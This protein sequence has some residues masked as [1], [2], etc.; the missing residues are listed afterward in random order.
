MSSQG[1]RCL[2]LMQQMLTDGSTKMIHHRCNLE[3]LVNDHPRLALISGDVFHPY[4]ELIMLK[5]FCPVR[6]QDVLLQQGVGAETMTAAV[7][8]TKKPP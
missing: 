2:E 4:S 1:A 7:S 8:D 5:L 3:M 6:S